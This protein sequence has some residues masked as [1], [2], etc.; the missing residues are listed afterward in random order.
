MLD[1]CLAHAAR[2]RSSHVAKLLKEY[3]MK[4]DADGLR[5]FG[6][7]VLMKA[8]LPAE[9]A[10]VSMDSLI[11]SELRGIKTHGLAHLKGYCRRIELGTVPASGQ[12]KYRQTAPSV[13]LVDTQH[14]TGMAAGMHIMEKCIGLA[15]QTGV[16]LAA[17]KNGS[18]FGFGGYF[19]MRAAE[20]GMIGACFANTPPLVAPFGG[21]EPLLGTNPIS[22]AIPAGRHPDFVLDMATSVVA[23]GKISEALKNGEPIP[24]GWAVDKMGRPTTNPTAA[25]IGALLPLGGPKGYGLA[26]MITLL[27]SALSG[28]DPDWNIARFWQQ[29][30][31]LTN[32]GFFMAAIDISK[33]CPLDEFRNRVDIIL[34]KLT[35]SRPAPDF[36]NVAIPGEIEF[37]ATQR[38]L[39]NGVELL[40]STV[41]DLEVISKKYEVPLPTCDA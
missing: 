19:A 2:S 27:T 35:S 37:N 17:A 41:R 20:R 18:H 28:A 21:A 33:F 40:E 15:V 23:K 26:L 9:D 4:Y 30:E 38:N 8:G 1:P 3:I 31:K 34:D 29:P 32:I 22:I 6:T 11:T 39:E 10:K 14:I 25:D 24:E 36:K 13:L 16:G 12:L 5:K 7:E